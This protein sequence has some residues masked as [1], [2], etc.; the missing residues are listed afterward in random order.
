MTDRGC[1]LELCKKATVRRTKAADQTCQHWPFSPREFQ[2]L[3]PLTTVGSILFL[4][5][6]L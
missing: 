6:L 4:V 5:S 2:D 1:C 3:T